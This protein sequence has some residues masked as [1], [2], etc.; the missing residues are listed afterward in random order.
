MTAKKE[1]V[2]PPWL[3]PALLVV[4]VALAYANSLNAPFLFDDAGAV[5]DNPTIRSLASLD[6]LRP[7]VDGST[8]TGRP[9]VNLSFALN[10]ALSGE[11]VWSYHA[12]NIALHAVAALLLFGLIRRTLSAVSSQLSAFNSAGLALAAASLWAL[13]PL[14]TESVVCIAQRTEILCG[15]FF[16][17]TLYAFARAAGMGGHV[18]VSAFRRRRWLTLSVTS[19]LLGMASK[20]V[21][22]TAPVVVLL[23][24][25]TFVAGTFAAAWRARRGYYGVLAATWLLLALLVAQSGGARGVAAGFD[26]GVSSWAYLL[27][28][29]EALVLYLRLAV[30]PH[31]LVLDYGTA[32]V[33]SVAEVWWQGLIV[34]ALLLGTAWALVRQPVAGFIGACFFLILAPSSSFVPLVTQT[35]A[36]HRMYLP[37][38]VLVTGFTVAVWRNFRRGVFGL[39]GSLAMICGVVTVLR[40]HDYRDAVVIWADTAHKRPENPRAHHNLALAWQQRG[41]PEQAN[42][43]F[44]RAIELQPDYAPARY[45]WGVALLDRGRLAEAN[46]QFSEAV[47]LSP[48]LRFDRKFAETQFELGRL[49]ERTGQPV[50]AE[51]KYREVLR[52][53]P[54]HVGALAKLG[55]LLA[56]SERFGPAAEQFRTLVLLQPGDADAHANLGNVLLLLGQPQAAL[57]SYEAAL[58]LRPDDPRTRENIRLA[59]E[60]VR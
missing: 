27:K 2:P 59:R 53:A 37:L 17:F 8:T 52:L 43:H 22:V 34:V 56:R 10:Y 1:F 9:L 31:P 20:E 30:W 6:V 50:E 16:L 26:L 24:D 60:A 51:V 42:Q 19:C 15:V 28:Q 11:R 58:R 33:R 29:C 7:P 39:L 41:K 49:A 35:I 36:E 12:T 46:T 3:A 48:A 18:P 55:L 5:T 45:N 57:A 21:M 40:T 4:A 44:A 32:V 13:H 14:Q 54:N 47:R 23:Y 25:R 38:A